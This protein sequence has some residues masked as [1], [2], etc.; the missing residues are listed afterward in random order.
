MSTQGPAFRSRWAS[1]W[2]ANTIM[3]QATKKPA[4]ASFAGPDVS[5][6]A[7]VNAPP[8]YAFCSIDGPSCSTNINPMMSCRLSTVTTP[9]LRLS[10]THGL[11]PA[12]NLRVKRLGQE[13]CIMLYPSTKQVD[14]NHCVPISLFPEA[15]VGLLFQSLRAEAR[16]ETEWFQELYRLRYAVEQT[17]EFP[18]DR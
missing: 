1:R 12:A 2:L 8:P 4:L 6:T 18:K 5:H 9:L 3:F 14:N 17:A 7:S 10:N 16:R 11:H 13:S 15:I